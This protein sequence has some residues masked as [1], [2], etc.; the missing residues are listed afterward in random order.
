MTSKE[1]QQ[2]KNWL[3]T[4]REEHK[5]NEDLFRGEE[6]GFPLYLQFEEVALP[7]YLYTASKDGA[8]SVY[9]GLEDEVIELEL[10]PYDFHD[11]KRMMMKLMEKRA[12]QSQEKVQ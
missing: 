4:K 1:Q 5:Q 7:F 2:L 8:H 9:Y 12:H 3:F 6:R 11:E 10:T